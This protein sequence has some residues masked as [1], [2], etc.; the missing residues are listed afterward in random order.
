MLSLPVFGMYDGGPT[1]GFIEGSVVENTLG[2]IAKHPAPILAIVGAVSYAGYRCGL[3][4]RRAQALG[5]GIAVASN[6]AMEFLG[7]YMEHKG[8]SLAPALD[9]FRSHEFRASDVIGGIGIAAVGAL[10]APPF[11][12]RDA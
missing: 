2:D 11:I 8:I 5:F 1:E 9:I 10:A 7:G 12:S 6:A 4:E 3:S